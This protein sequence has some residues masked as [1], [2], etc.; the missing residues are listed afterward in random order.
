MEPDNRSPFSGRSNKTSPVERGFP[1]VGILPQMLVDAPGELARIALGHPNAVPIVHLGP[2]RIYLVTHPDHVE[3]VLNDN[4]RNFGKTGPMWA[5]FRRLLGNGLATSEGEVWRRSRRLMQPLFGAKYLAL[6]VETMADVTGRAIARLEPYAARG[7]AI[8]MDAEMMSLTQT[9]LLETMFGAS[10]RPGEAA[11]IGEAIVTAFR[12]LNLR[13]FF[14]TFPTWLPLPGE[15]SLRR[16]VAMID[17][18]ILGLVHDRRKSREQRDDLLSLLLN[19]RDEET[20]A[21]MDDRQLRDELVTLF[22]A[23]N[24]TTAITMSWLWYVLDRFPEV[25]RKVRAEIEVVLGGRTPTADDLGSLTYSKMLIQEVLR[26]YPPAWFLPRVAAKA[27]SICGY[28][29]P[30]GATILLNQYGAH[31]HP[32]FWEQPSVLDPERFSPER[33]AGRHRYAFFPF[34]GGAR[35]CIGNLFAIMESQVIL[36]MMVQRFRPRLEAG[37]PEV[38]PRSATTLRPHPMLRMTLEPGRSGRAPSM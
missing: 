23:G 2:A 15:Q 31:R 33:S 25:D 27:D 34:G 3:Y 24:E 19:A 20:Q 26:L 35:Q 4:W 18:A 22:I 6:L 7:A 5:L 21:G 16:A 29:V 17:E 14:S 30:A 8:D 12:A 10:L 37:H 28:A 13:M 36:A 1:L 32:S 11:S 9:V 38:R